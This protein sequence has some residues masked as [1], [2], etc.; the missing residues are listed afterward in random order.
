MDVDQFLS[1]VFPSKRDEDIATPRRLLEYGTLQDHIEEILAKYDE[2]TKPELDAEERALTDGRIGPETVGVDR[3]SLCGSMTINDGIEIESR[4]NF[5]SVRANMCVCKGKWMYEILLGSKGIMQLGWATLQCKFTNEEGVG[6]TNDSFAYDGHRVRKWNVSTA[7]Y[8]EEWMAGDVVGCFID[9]DQGVISY[10]RNGHFLG[11]AFDNVQYGPGL[12]YF[13]AASLS[14]GESCHMNFGSAPFKFPIE[15][16]KPL[17]DPPISD[18]AK[19]TEMVSCLDRLLP[20]P[21]RVPCLPPALHGRSDTLTLLTTAYVFEKLGPLLTGGYVVEEVLLPF[22]LK[23]CV[24]CNPVEHR[25]G[26]HKILDMMWV[27]MEEFELVPSLS[28]LLN[29]LIKYYWFQPVTMDFRQQVHCLTLVLSILK[30]EKTR[31][32]WIA[33]KSFPQKFSYFMHIKPPDDKVLQ[34]SFPSVWWES[35]DESSKPSEASKTEYTTA[36]NKLKNKVQVLENIQVEICKILLKGDD[37]P[38]QDSK[39]T[40]L[41]FLEKFRKFLQEN[42]MTIML[43]PSSACAGPV[44]TCFYHRLVQAVRWHWEQWAQE[45]DSPIKSKDAYVP[46]HVFHDDGVHFWDLP[47]VGGVLSHLKKAYHDAI[48]KSANKEEPSEGDESSISCEDRNLEPSLVE[49]L[50]GVIMLYHIAVHKQ[51]SKVRAVRENMKQNIKA[52]EETMAKIRRCEQER[53]DVLAELERSKTVFLQ[54]TTHCARHMAWVSTL[55]FTKEKQNDVHWMLNCIMSS[56]E[57]GTIK[58]NLFEFTPEF[59][60]EAAINAFHG[61]RHYFHPTTCFS[62][63]PESSDTLQKMAAFLCTHF[64]DQRIINPDLRDI[65]IQALAAFVCYPDSLEAVENM[66]E[67]LLEKAIRSLMAAYDKRSWVQTTWILVRIWKGCGFA[68]RYTSSPDVITLGLPEQGQQR[69]SLQPPHPSKKCQ[70]QFGQLCV[71]DNQLASEFLN[72]LLNQLNWSFS[73]F[74]GML[75]EIQQATHQMETVLDSRQLRT[76]AVCFDLTVGLMRVL[77]MVATVAPE[78]FTDWKRQSAELHIARLFQLLTQVLNRVTAGSNLFENVT[79]L[80]LP[81]LETVDRFPIL[82]AVTGILLTLLLDGTIES[83]ERATSSL[84]AEPGYNLDTVCFLVGG[85][86]VAVE[87]TKPKFSFRTLINKDV[88]PEEVQRVDDLVSHL[89]SQGTEYG[90]QTQE[91]VDVDDLCPICCAVKVSVRFIPCLHVSCRSCISR[92]LMNNKECF[93]CKH[94]VNELEDITSEEAV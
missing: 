58:E 14:Y 1:T 43:Q 15:G 94:I 13:P 3:A 92:H 24:G 10:S 68:F 74:I 52:L 2:E 60:M 53:T 28:H 82:G 38:T 26:V 86:S 90:L 12:A 18:V 29:A 85:K 17:Q 72:G 56:V 88:T 79:R 48:E 49:M 41:L 6:D 9:L 66:P 23:S 40:R 63:I 77:E 93:F 81:G 80:H 7:K 62:D 22:L 61:L 42:M 87:A 21:D 47:R 30:H 50:D 67:T 45:K 39:P 32:L 51:L 20:A 11:V 54:E 16:Y 91:S 46:N 83:K 5:S 71:K 57:R 76:C 73:E 78:V 27:C 59:Y 89:E 35:D 31:R 37:R 69:A 34:S 8:G 64:I 44:I 70:Q 4:S 36:C 84:L 65:I 55:I 33:C 25:P 75:Q 19:A